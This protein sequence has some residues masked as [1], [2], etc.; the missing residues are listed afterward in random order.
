MTL[1]YKILGIP[2]SIDEFVDKAALLGIDKVNIYGTKGIRDIESFGIPYLISVQDDDKKT[3]YNELLFSK[4]ILSNDKS[5]DG[6]LKFLDKAKKWEEIFKNNGIDSR[7]LLRMNGY[8]VQLTESKEK[9][10][11][12]RVEHYNHTIESAEKI[13]QVYE[14]FR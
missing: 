8:E 1:L 4:S 2:G 7:I 14:F 10:I 11:I 6:V 13:L 12:G 9:D 5:A 3:E